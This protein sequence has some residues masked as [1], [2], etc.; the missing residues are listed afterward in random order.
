IQMRHGDWT[1]QTPVRKPVTESDR[2]LQDC[3]QRPHFTQIRTVEHRFC[4]GFCTRKRA[5]AFGA[6]GWSNSPRGQ[7]SVRY[8]GESPPE[9]L[10]RFSR[11]FN[12]A[13]RREVVWAT[14]RKA[15]RA[16]R[17]SHRGFTELGAYELNRLRRTPVYT[18]YPW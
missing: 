18:F 4:T 15:P 10:S 3:E 8:R 17:H 14:D 7:L 13:D 2:F 9:S 16:V 6:S 5:S 11:L 12:P 1:T